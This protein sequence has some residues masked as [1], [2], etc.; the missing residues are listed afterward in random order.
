MNLSAGLG[1]EEDPPTESDALR[2][3]DTGVMESEGSAVCKHGAGASG[4]AHMNGRT[5]HTD[6]LTD[7]TKRGDKRVAFT[8]TLLQNYRLWQVEVR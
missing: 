8:C 6:A 4:D 5:M 2:Q 3:S 1:Y 7:G